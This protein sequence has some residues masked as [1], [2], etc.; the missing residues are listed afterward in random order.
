[1]LK[2]EMIANLLVAGDWSGS[3]MNL[4]VSFWLDLLIR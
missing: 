1:M 3:V 4:S 2:A